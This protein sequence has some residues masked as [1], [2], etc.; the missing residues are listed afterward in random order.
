MV[1]TLVFPTR[2]IVLDSWRYTTACF[3]EAVGFL[4]LFAVLRCE[5]MVSLSQ[6]DRSVSEAAS[7]VGEAY[8]YQAT[9]HSE[10]M[11]HQKRLQRRSTEQKRIYAQQMRDPKATWSTSALATA[12]ILFSIDVRVPTPECVC[13]VLTNCFPVACPWQ[14]RP[15]LL[16]DGHHLKLYHS[17]SKGQTA[18]VIF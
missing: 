15:L 18:P 3:H 16:V 5:E 2:A 12:A 9:S 8:L 6:T 10:F 11:K 1:Q 13:E 7:L 17:Y 4:P 14:H